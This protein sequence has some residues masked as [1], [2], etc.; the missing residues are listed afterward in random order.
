[1]KCLYFNADQ[2]LNKME[3]LRSTIADNPPDIIIVTEVIP[4]AQKHPIQEPLLKIDGF[5]TFTNFAFT[6]E[7]LGIAGKRGVAFFVNSKLETE[8]VNLKANYDDHLWIQIQLRNRDS[9]LCGCMYRTPNKD[10]VEETTKAVCDVITE[11]VAR[12][13]THLLIC[14]DFNYPDIDWTCEFVKAESV[15]LF[16]DTIQ[17]CHLYQHVCKSTRYREGQMPSLLDL[18]LSTEEGLV[19]N[20]VHNPGIGDSDHECLSFDLT[21]Y[22]D[23]CEE[24]KIPNFLKADFETIRSRIEDIDWIPTLRGEFLDAYCKFESIL[25]EAMTGCVPDKGKG[26]KKKNLYLTTE[27]VKLKDRKNHLWR[28]YKKSGMDYDLSRYRQVKNRLRSLTR[29]LRRNFEMDIAKD[30]KSA[31]KKFWSYVKSR[32]KTRSKIPILSRKDGSKATSPLEKAETLN[33]FFSSVF[34]DEHIESIPE[35]SSDFLGNYLSQFIITQ[36]VVQEKLEKLNPGKTPGPDKWH[37][38]LLKGIAD[39]I[40]L[41]LSILFQKSLNEGI[42]PMGWLNAIITAI[43]KKGDKGIA[44]NYRPV[45]MTSIICKLMESIIRDKL[46]EHMITNDLFSK[47]QHGFVPLRDCMTNLLTCMEKWS[48]FLERDDSIDVIYTDFSKAFDSVPHQRLLR[49]LENMGITGNVLA[50]IRSFLSNRSQCVRVEDAVS[51]WKPVKSGIPQGSVLGPIL[52]VIFINDMPEMVENLCELFAD[53]AKLF[54]DVHLRDEE[55]NRSLQSDLD[56]L[57]NWSKKWQLPFNVGKCKCLHI[58]NSNPCWKYKMD[59]R[60]LEDVDEEKDLG[61]MIDK[62]L[63]FHRQ[64]ALA[65]KKANMA[66][67]L[68]K[69]S[70]AFL[71]DQTLPLLFKPLVRSHL[72]YGNVIWGPFYKGD[73][74]HVERIQRRATKGV[75]GLGALPYDERLRRLKLPSLQHRRRRGDMIMVYKI[76]TGK[77][78]LNRNDFFTFAPNQTNRGSHDFKLMKKKA[79]KDVRRNTFSTRVIDDWNNLPKSV[80]NAQSTDEF[81]QK[82]DNHW[83]TEEECATPF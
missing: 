5:E 48:E 73:S 58:G 2:L 81:K 82:L 19:H 41:P 37:P 79:I 59:G 68:V 42:L 21:C 72:E 46:V 36:E 66:L 50:W 44:N 75:P 12:E 35:G 83:G 54:R 26:K 22:K 80:V 6:E 10:K 17:R 27:A 60:C 24:M 14:G 76:I 23:N 49:K 40:S 74:Q 8:V 11:A 13:P 69:K 53:D 16:I 63:K 33:N 71:D 29:L 32:T 47:Q 3:E 45:S 43:H 55:K 18:I 39:L 61:V 65:V 64:T 52:F 57:V 70:F 15:K 30:A 77:V 34:T 56:A 31:P 51:E 25:E 7:N 4:K 28:R 78:N 20:L 1:M 62:E 67:G 38:L 9:L